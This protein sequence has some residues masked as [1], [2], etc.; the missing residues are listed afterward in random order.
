MIKTED[1]TLQNLGLSEG[2]PIF[3]APGRV[4][5]EGEYV[6]IHR[7]A[8]AASSCRR[9]CILDDCVVFFADS[10]SVCCCCI[11]ECSHI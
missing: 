11:M 3:V 2:S 9:L 6:H 10:S 8:F 1:S 7:D 5:K 4:L